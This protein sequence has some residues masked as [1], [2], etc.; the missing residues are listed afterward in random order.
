MQ[1]AYTLATASP[2]TLWAVSGVNSSC[3]F[4]HQSE[5]QPKPGFPFLRHSGGKGKDRVSGCFLQGRKGRFP[6]LNQ[7]P[8]SVSASPAPDSVLMNRSIPDGATLTVS[9]GGG[10]VFCK[11]P[12]A[13]SFCA[14]PARRCLPSAGGEAE[15]VRGAP[16]PAPAPGRARASAGRRSR[17]LPRPAGR[18]ASTAA[19]RALRP[20]GGRAGAPSGTAVSRHPAQPLRLQRGGRGWAE[21]DSRG[22]GNAGCGPLTQ[23]K[24]NESVRAILANK[25]V[26]SVKAELSFLDLHQAYE[27]SAAFKKTPKYSLWQLQENVDG[28]L[29]TLIK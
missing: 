24:R 25:R 23:Q 5:V 27:P 22:F 1:P 18:L 21:Q 26:Q 13:L 15:A 20:A 29:K 9:P 16:T 28:L 14:A 10:K 7:V 6:A 3:P 12:G 11:V 4:Y 2:T 17:P 19:R 8:R